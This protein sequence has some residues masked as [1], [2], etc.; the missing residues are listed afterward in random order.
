MKRI[1]LLLFLLLAP[2]LLAKPNVIVSIAPQK[3]FVQKIAMD[4][5]DLTVMVP[6]GS[7]PHSYEPKPSQMIALSNADVYFGINIGFENVWLEK[8][9]TQNS[10]LLFVDISANV[11][12]IPSAKNHHHH[13]DEETHH[14]ETDHIKMDPHT[15]LVPKDVAIMAQSIYET[16]VKISPQN[17][18][19]Y[20][21]NY[22]AFLQEIQDTDTQIKQLFKDLPSQTKFMAFHPSWGYFAKTYDLKQIAIE[23]EGKSPKPKE[24]IRI[25]KE[26]KEDKVK[27]IFTQPE[28]SD[29]SAQII[30]KEA[31]VRVEKISPLNPQWSQ[32]LINMAEA[33]A[34]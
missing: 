14:E 26:A 34:K 30:A 28:F 1:F 2:L 11:K 15:W 31:D 20:T 32:N 9:K 27:V 21:K 22:N 16:L 18:E 13:H 24:I 33:I 12:R 19:A 10:K 25:I 6:E 23:V 7:S 4:M 17:K 3:T 29:K 5:V 8:F